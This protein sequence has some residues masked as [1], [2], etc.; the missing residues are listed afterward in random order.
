MT[1]AEFLAT[2]KFQYG[3]VESTSTTW[4]DLYGAKQKKTDKNVTSWRIRLERMLSKIMKSGKHGRKDELKRQWW[5]ELYS[6]PLKI[7]SR[8]KVDDAKVTFTDIFKYVKKLDAE[9]GT[10]SRVTSAQDTCNGRTYGEGR[11]RTKIFEEHMK[12]ND[13]RLD[14]L[15]SAVAE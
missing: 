6:K 7:G 12:R 9:E 3:E 10:G 11:Y 8:H 15:V 2:L 1:V 5:T 14:S 13:E 4:K